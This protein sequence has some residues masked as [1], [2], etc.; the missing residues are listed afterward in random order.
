MLHQKILYIAI[1]VVCLGAPLFAE[2]FTT[3]PPSTK[4]IHI[5]AFRYGT[6]PAIIRAN[7]GDELVLTFSTRDTGHSFFLQDYRIDAKITPASETVEVRDPLQPTE[8]P[9]YVQEIPLKAGLPGLW[10]S[11]VSISRFRC[12]VYCG[13]MHGFEQGDLIVRP[14]WLM[15]GSLGLLLS[16]VVIGCLRVRLKS[17]VPKTVPPKP[18]DLNKRFVLLDRLLKW[19]PLQFICTFPVLAGLMVVLLAGF[20][21]TKVGGRNVAVML[22]WIVW[23]SM[24][25]LFLVPLGGRIW[26]MICPLPVMGEY[27]QRGAT[28][29][30]RAGRRGRFGNRF[31][32]LGRQWP[33]ALRGPWLRLFLFL[34]LGA[35]SA[36]LAGQP[37]WTAITLIIMV[38]AGAFMS[39][40]WELRSFCRYVCP[41]AG[42]IS[43]YSAIGRLMVR[44]R[45]PD[46]CR[47][48]KDKPC[49]KG[50]AAGWACPY[51][52][53]VSQID[54]NADCGIC[55]EC[56]K[57][58]PN[59]NV[60]LAWRRG[61]WAEHF[62]SYGEAWQAIVLLV[63]AIAYS[64][65]VHS[66]WPIMR[67]MVNMVDKAS[68]SEFGLFFATLCAIALGAVPL[69]F[70]LMCGLG[71][72]LSN[73][74]QK[75]DNGAPATQKNSQNT[76]FNASTGKIFKRTLPALLPLGLALWAVF[77]V[78]TIMA[79]M[80][81]I[82]LSFS[83]PFGWG[84]D[85]LGTAGMPWIQIWPS[86]I[87]W[88]Q[89]GIILFGVTLSLKKGYRLWNNEVEG[90]TNALRGFAPTAAILLI[91]AG[92]MLIYLTNY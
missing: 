69:V 50:N 45:N 73:G 85:L 77:F 27:L 65:T 28:T 47:S 33:R 2:W 53:M 64:L 46:V 35:F 71:L 19:R 83:D 86:G 39:V 79:N 84:W 91:V 88:T 32:G 14:N 30:V 36:S 37:K 80:T 21:G 55:T 62:R 15:A 61:P 3:P 81:F 60:S 9:S 43:A 17:P 22:T 72:R 48:C 16:I 13:P 31:F 26:C 82:L 52:L 42:F 90:T 75:A 5:E 6:S 58:C 11:L 92:G 25:A 63:L 70:W 59:D 44:K 29:E 12:H 56:F 40:V 57:S 66:P 51:G 78:E 23:I 38:A 24:L 41:V 87:P 89:V 74:T 8:P 49:F 54:R 76:L 4:K 1:I 18:I 20:F 10:G 34:I 68:L 7:R 67:N